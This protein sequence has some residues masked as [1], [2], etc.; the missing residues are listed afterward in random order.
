MTNP[1]YECKKKRKRD[2]FLFNHIFGGDA[3]NVALNMSGF[4]GLNETD[5]SMMKDPLIN[6]NPNQAG[7]NILSGLNSEQPTAKTNQTNPKT[8]EN[9]PFAAFMKMNTMGKENSSAP[10]NNKD[11]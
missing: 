10:E 2:V 6:K 7:N 1:A 4:L 9:N 5:K 3:K 11:G 8:Q